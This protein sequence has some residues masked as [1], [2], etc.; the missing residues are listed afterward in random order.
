MPTSEIDRVRDV[1]ERHRKAIEERY[2]ALGSG[3]G[4]VSAGSSTLAIVVYLESQRDRPA[5]PVSVEG[6]P[7][8]FEITG[9]VR[10]LG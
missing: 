1:L 6:V 10:F 4:K 2:H 9:P 5:T 8:R 7:L 3:I